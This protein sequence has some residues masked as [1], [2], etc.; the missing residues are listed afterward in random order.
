MR[1]EIQIS[2][3]HGLVFGIPSGHEST[4]DF[5]QESTP[6]SEESTPEQNSGSAPGQKSGLFQIVPNCSNSYRM[7]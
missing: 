2:S 1:L 4:P 6:E 5:G 7:R 3:S